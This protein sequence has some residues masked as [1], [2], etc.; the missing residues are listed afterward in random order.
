MIDN[1]NSK[2]TLIIP[3]HNRPKHLRRLLGYFNSCKIGCKIV[4]A[5]SSITE[6]KVRN[7][8]TVSLFTGLDISY[9]DH[10]LPDVN[11]W[12]KWLEAISQ[13]R[14]DYAVICADDDFVVPNCINEAVIFLEKNPDFVLAHG[15]Y[16]SFETIGGPGKKMQFSWRP[17]YPHKT[18]DSSDPRERIVSHFSSYY[19]TLYAVHRTCI[20]KKIFELTLKYPTENAHMNELLCSMFS[21][22]YGK[23]KSINVFY[24]V[25]ETISDSCSKVL[26]D[27]DSMIGE[28]TYD[29]EY[30]K[31]KH[32][33]AVHLAKEARISKE[34][35]GEI[36]DKGMDLYLKR[37]YSGFS[38]K[39]KNKIGKLDLP[40][41]LNHI[42]KSIYVKYLNSKQPKGYLDS[43]INS[44]DFN[45]IC[46]IIMASLGDK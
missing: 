15:K 2:V 27:I 40:F 24:S 8:E 37:Y 41:G 11:G 35:A 43:L 33:L 5:D 18:I 44:E 29:M 6:N 12:I 19:P 21:L 23:S 25:K 22:V 16:V 28:G 17:I 20:L 30:D 7:K 46:I 14:S 32:G 3:T 45:K 10:F 4:I 34:E 39:L 38:S 13:A 42:I 31:F 26:K 36:I 1:L 9:L